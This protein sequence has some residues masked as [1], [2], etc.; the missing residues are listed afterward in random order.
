MLAKPRFS[1]KLGLI[2]LRQL[3]HRMVSPPELLIAAK[4]IDF[5]AP[6]MF[7]GLPFWELERVNSLFDRCGKRWTTVRQLAERTSLTIP[8][9]SRLVIEG[10]LPKITA[11]F[12]VP[13]WHEDDLKLFLSQRD[14]LGI[15]AAGQFDIENGRIYPLLDSPS[16]WRALGR[17][18]AFDAFMGQ[19]GHPVQLAD[20]SFGW[21]AEHMDEIRFRPKK[22]TGS[23]EATDEVQP[24]LELS[25]DGP[26]LR[27]KCR[28]E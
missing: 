22:S 27:P 15:S 5:V 8:Q 16:P 2:S 21:V 9:I 10:R 1:E 17:T 24:G 6:L 12:F 19:L 20:G 7:A 4:E 3:S 25:V 26:L 14:W 11:R 13:G 18:A 28:H 23:V